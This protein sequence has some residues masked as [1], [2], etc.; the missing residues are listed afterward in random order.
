MI[1]F[2][3]SVTP[4]NITAGDYAALYLDGE[5]AATKAEAE[6][7]SHVRWITVLG[8][9]DAGCGDFEPG[10]PLY[11]DGHELRA[12]AADRHAARK[13]VRVYCDRADAAE[14]ARRVAGIPHEWWIS[15]LDGKRWTAAELAADLAERWG[16]K[17]D[18]GRIWANQYQGGETAPEDVSDL[19]GTW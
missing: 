19:Y 2:F 13:R 8:D 6:R 12:W 5:F 16:V 7:F 4:G 14:A 10:N 11:D 18:P 15:T 3:D 1:K 17:I 9:P